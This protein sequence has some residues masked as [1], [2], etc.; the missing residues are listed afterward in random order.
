MNSLRAALTFCAF[1]PLAVFAAETV[2]DKNP[3]ASPAAPA[4]LVAQDST[5]LAIAYGEYRP[6]AEIN[7]GA[8]G[9]VS[10]TV[11]DGELIWL[12]AIAD[13]TRLELDYEAKWTQNRFKG[14][15]PYGDTE[16]HFF[17]VHSVHMF[18]KEFGIGGVAAVELASETSA[19]LLREGLRGGAG[20]SFVWNISDTL[21]TETGGSIQTMFGDSPMLSPYVSWKWLARPDLELE[22]RASG[23]QNGVQG[24]WYI[25]ENKAT[26]LRVSL[27]YETSNYA[28]RDG[29]GAEGVFVGEVPLRVTFTQ[30]LCK[31]F[32]V[33]A[34][35]EVTLT[36]RES[37]YADDNKV[38]G[39]Q[40]GV[41]PVYALMCGLRL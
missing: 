24:V 10:R 29:A 3:S 9:S 8:S 11:A 14:V 40:T 1:A 16:S 31:E 34:R 17:G 38:G 39:F 23:R 28:L 19:D 20:A 35:A 26:S 12:G 32:F 36:H 33:A 21:K 18:D 27:M 13:D 7:N 4:P 41:A 25:T 37:F 6:G 22:A 2:S 30:F 15:Q 5:F